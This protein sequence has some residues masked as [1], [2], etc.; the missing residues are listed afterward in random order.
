MSL[1]FD[2]VLDVLFVF[3]EHHL[4]RGFAGAKAGQA[5]CG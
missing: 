2:L 3:A 4:A 1:R 5:A